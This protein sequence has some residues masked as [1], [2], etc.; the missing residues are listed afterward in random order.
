MNPMLINTA[1]KEEP[2]SPKPSFVTHHNNNED[3]EMT[4]VPSHQKESSPYIKPEDEEM[5][6]SQAIGK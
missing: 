4:D 2:K 5:N 1:T 6:D 3:E